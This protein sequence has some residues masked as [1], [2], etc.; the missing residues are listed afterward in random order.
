MALIV[1]FIILTV[2]ASFLA[3]GQ[4]GPME[5]SYQDLSQ[6]LMQDD[7]GKKIDFP[8][9][10]DLDIQEMEPGDTIIISDKV[11]Y[12]VSRFEPFFNKD[13]TYVWFNSS[14]EGEN[15]NDW[16]NSS[17]GLYE[18]FDVIIEG[19][20]TDDYIAGD[21]MEL[22]FHVTE[23]EFEVD[24]KVVK[25]EFIEELW[26]SENETL[27]FVL[28]ERV[29]EEEEDDVLLGG[30][31]DTVGTI[32]SISVLLI[33]VIAI[34]LGY[35]TIAG[36]AENGS[37]YV[38]LSY[39]VRRSEVLLGKFIGLGFVIV[40]S[41]IVGFGAGGLIIAITVGTASSLGFLAFIGLT[42]L[43]GLLYLA[44]TIMASA[45]CKRKVTA[46]AAGII[47][48][49]WAMIYGMIIMGIYLATGGNM[50]DFFSGNIV[51]PDWLWRSVFFSPG[52][53]YQMAVMQ[54]FGIDQLFGITVETP[55]YLTLELLVGVML[56]WT[57]IPM[58]LAYFFFEKR[59]I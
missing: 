21:G 37:L 52:D 50:G 39:P 12:I 20:H 15:V 26:D 9:D 11:E 8:P 23:L 41:C 3:G 4:A 46:L 24:S 5:L 25:V 58:I 47:I 19:N 59:D 53:M 30:M 34:M 40:V 13:I 51:F 10:E 42:I 27:R 49:F 44:L 38:V 32:M 1:I 36:E 54:A 17:S 29:L 28:P 55:G 2:A 18:N 48:F 57:I 14:H 56:L 7:D 31:E 16:Y 6:S 45:F 35:S 43:I 33:P 22:T